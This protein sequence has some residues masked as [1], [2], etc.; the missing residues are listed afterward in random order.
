MKKGVGSETMTVL[1][2]EQ[3]TNKQMTNLS[4]ATCLIKSAD[5]TSFSDQML[6]E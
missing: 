4:E 3:D 5:E 6:D 1:T 2:D